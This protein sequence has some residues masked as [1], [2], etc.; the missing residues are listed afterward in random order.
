M[1]SAKNILVEDKASGTQLIQDLQADRVHCVTRYEPK[2]EKIMRMH[3]VTSTIENGFVSIPAQ[4]EWLPQYL[5]KLAVFPN[6]KYD[7]QV[8]STSQALDWINEGAGC[9][10]VLEWYK[11]ESERLGYS[12]SLT[13]RA[14]LKFPDG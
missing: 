6:G 5:H 4:A 9:Y 10:G 13:S 12:N 3:S 8:A 1:Y 14:F 11:Q 7:D 2:M